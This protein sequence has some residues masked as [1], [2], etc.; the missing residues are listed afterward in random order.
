MT[1]TV[2]RQATVSRRVGA[3]DTAAAVGS[4]DLP[5]LGTPVVVAALEQAACA[6]LSGTLA[7]GQT[8]VGIHLDV[9][10]VA[11]SAVGAVIHATATLEEVDGRRLRFSVVAAQDLPD[12]AVEIARGTHARVVVDRERFLAGVPG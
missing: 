3:A 9:S 5:V 2:G 8:S 11:P 10:H 1:P 7:D 12:G 4:G 6:A